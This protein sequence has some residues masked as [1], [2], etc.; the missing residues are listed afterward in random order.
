MKFFGI[1]ILCLGLCWGQEASELCDSRAYADVTWVCAH[2]AMSNAEDFWLLPNQKHNIASLLRGGIHAQMWDVWMKQGVPTL[3]HGN[4][5]FFDPQNK[6]LLI[7]LGE[8]KS[9]LE[10]QPEAI[11]T[12]ILETYIA[13]ELL[14]Q[15]V[16]KAGLMPMVYKGGISSLSPRLGD[17]RAANTRLLILSDKPSSNFIQL[18]DVAVETNWE[19]KSITKL[20]NK[21]RRGRADNP[22]FIVNH[23][24]SAA[25]PSCAD[26]R[27]LNT[28]QAQA[29]RRQELELLYARRPN[30]WVM[31]FIQVQ[32]PTPRGE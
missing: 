4:G 32:K 6:P 18:W 2:N 26:A 20:D 12:L 17:L 8:V 1:L 21:L 29:A 14:A 30:F 9:Y 10:A 5:R 28:K 15:C 27:K 22:L 24:I 31:D 13:D 19:N 3:R 7:A 16:T 11:I 25:I 23:F